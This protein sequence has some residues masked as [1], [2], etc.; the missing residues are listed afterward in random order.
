MLHNRQGAGYFQVPGYFPLAGRIAVTISKS[1]DELQHL[2]L[3]LGKFIRWLWLTGS[4]MTT[5]MDLPRSVN[6]SVCYSKKNGDLDI[7]ESRRLTG[8]ICI[9]SIIYSWLE[10]LLPWKVLLTLQ[11]YL[12]KKAGR[13]FRPALVVAV[14]RQK[15]T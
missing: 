14:C 6:Q 15:I 9:C 10:P 3:A 12:Y 1:G 13:K 4:H 5:I 7:S 11:D 8:S 2:S